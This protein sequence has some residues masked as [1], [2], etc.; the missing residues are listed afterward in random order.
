MRTPILIPTLTL[1]AILVATH[2]AT[3]S[4]LLA[5]D[6]L[7]RTAIDSLLGESSPGLQS[8]ASE[9]RLQL[10]SGRTIDISKTFADE[11]AAMEQEL[12]RALRSRKPAMLRI[13]YE[14]S[15]RPLL[16]ASRRGN[17]L[18]GAF[19]SFTDE[20]SPVALVGY[21]R[22]E[23]DAALLTW[24]D[25]GRPIVFAQYQSGEL[26]GLRCLFKACCEECK[27]G[28]LAMV[29]EWERGRLQAVHRIDPDGNTISHEYRYG[30]PSSDSG[31]ETP[32]GELASFESQFDADE[33]KLKRM[34]AQYHMQDRQAAAL[35]SR[36]SSSQQ[37][38]RMLAAAYGTATRSY[39]HLSPVRVSSGR[40]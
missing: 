35:R 15:E 3:V 5:D 4:H 8:E 25:T 1:M 10:S 32:L 12:G 26:N 31:F 38:N 29:Q 7:N 33:G 19:A 28:H 20:G 23:R 21:S 40:V 14:G 6:N 9:F 17:R 27:S 13:N 30:D 36:L 11:R 16:L 2:G 18:D 24:D 37:R 22:G 39:R 34:L